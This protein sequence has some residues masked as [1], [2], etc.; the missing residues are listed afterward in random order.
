MVIVVP[1]GVP[2]CLKVVK[3]QSPGG[4]ARTRLVLVDMAREERRAKDSLRVE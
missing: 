3:Q 1:T 2:S 4:P